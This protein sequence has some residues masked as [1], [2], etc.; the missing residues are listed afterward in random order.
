MGSGS[1]H[2][3]MIF[4]ILNQFG[5][6]PTSGQTWDLELG[7]G[8]GDL[9]LGQGTTLYFVDPE[10]VLGNVAEG[11]GGLDWQRVLRGH[12]ATA[13]FPLVWRYFSTLTTSTTEAVH[14]CLSVSLGPERQVWLEAPDSPTV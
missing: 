9:I 14:Y 4:R 12:G 13:I 1:A 3:G 2:E 6:T 7:H 11:P 8:P 5:H 10:K